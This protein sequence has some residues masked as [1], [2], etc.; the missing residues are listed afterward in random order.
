MRNW[1]TFSGFFDTEYYRGVFI[2]TYTY[3]A[4]GLTL[5]LTTGYF[6]ITVLASFRANWTLEKC[7][8]L[9]NND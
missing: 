7:Y 1:N 8:H 2:N 4:A 6:Y 9:N 3:N 5:F